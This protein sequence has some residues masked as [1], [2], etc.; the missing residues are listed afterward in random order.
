MSPKGSLQNPC[1][2][3]THECKHWVD[4]QFPPLYT[5]GKEVLRRSNEEL[6]PTINKNHEQAST[7][8]LISGAGDPRGCCRH[9]HSGW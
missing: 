1:P 8:L 3:S 2:L 4:N 6:T 9:D 7:W 5:P